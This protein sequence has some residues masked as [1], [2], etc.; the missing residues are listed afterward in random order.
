M[1]SRGA[2][3][4]RMGS[5][6]ETDGEQGSDGRGA[7]EQRMGISGPAFRPRLHLC[8]APPLR[9][10][11]QS[12]RLEGAPANP[13]SPFRRRCTGQPHKVLKSNESSLAM[14]MTEVFIR[15]IYQK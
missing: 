13:P 11:A 8:S 12:R 4:R 15:H 5:R 6:G 9:G 7:G 3:E 10:N 14:K 1:G 2:G